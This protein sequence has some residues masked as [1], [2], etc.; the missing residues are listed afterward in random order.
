MLNTTLHGSFS[1][2]QAVRVPFSKKTVL[3]MNQGNVCTKF[4]LHG[5]CVTNHRVDRKDITIIIL[6]TKLVPDFILHACCFFTPGNRHDLKQPPRA[7]KS[8][9]HENRPVSDPESEIFFLITSEIQNL[10]HFAYFIYCQ[11]SKV[12][13]L[14][15]FQVHYNQ[16]H[17]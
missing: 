6:D 16:C 14:L 11:S 17:T 10:G 2:L 7:S 3:Y 4:K 5:F 15:N 1:K 8:L 9:A 12:T 13:V